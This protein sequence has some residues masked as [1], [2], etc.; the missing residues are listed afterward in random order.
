VLDLVVRNGTVVDGTGGP[1]VQADVGVADGRIVGLGRVGEQAR[2]TIE[3]DGLVVCPGFVDIHT[4]YDAQVLWDPTLSPSPLHGVT[5]VVGGNCG[6]SIAP[7]EPDHVDYV[8]RMMARVEGMPLDALQAGPAWDWRSYRQWLDRIDGRLAVNAGFL[9]G[10]ST[11]RRLA[12]GDKAVGGTATPY[13]L[14]AMVRLAHDAMRAGAL[15]VSS[16]LGEGHTDGDGR[17]VPS[18]SAGREEFLALA[19]AASDHPGTSLEFI[20]AMGE[21]PQERIELMTDM[22]L[23]ANR[24]LNWNLLGSLSPV[25]VYE[26]QLTACDWAA[27]HGAT[28]V[29]LALPDLLRMRAGAMLGGLPAWQEVLRLPEDDRRRRA[30]DPAARASLRAGVEQASQRGLEV[31]GRWD[32]IEIADGDLVGR[33][34]AQV[35]SERRVEPIEVLIDTVVAEGRPV[36]VVFPSLVP[37]LGVSEESWQVRAKVWKDER[38]VLGGSDAGAH[39]DLMCHANYTTVVLGDLVRERQL[40]GLEEAVR[41]LTDVPA[42]LYGLRGRGRLAEGWHADLVVFDPGRVGSEPARPRF[43][44]PAGACRVYAGS[45]GVDHVVVAGEEVV[46]A[47]AFTG[48]LP[49]TLLRSG[50]D[51]QT[52]T[53]PAGRRHRIESE[54][55]TGD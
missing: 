45:R 36:S 15:G 49:G 42:R 53:V 2:R 47:G 9:V 5:S 22:S 4:H 48:A 34:I 55:A 28:V 8:M 11:L 7:L 14:A 52:V 17:P 51:T 40:F 37:T 29:A 19:A 25:E 18:R 1:G 13:H 39:V 12:M 21:I 26:Q 33:S 20:A 32:L 10:H 50:T 38:V 31:L 23:A 35:A 41:L 24:P 46:T 3:A 27:A 43:D 6:F 54:E 30:G 16:S 44:M